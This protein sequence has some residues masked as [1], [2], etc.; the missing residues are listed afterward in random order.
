M[1]DKVILATLLRKFSVES[2]QTVDEAKPAGQLILRPTEGKIL[3][4]LVSR[5]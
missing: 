4:K 5:K 3:V 1:E 2:A